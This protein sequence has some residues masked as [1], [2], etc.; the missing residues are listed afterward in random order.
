[1]IKYIVNWYKE[2]QLKHHNCVKNC[3]LIDTYTNSWKQSVGGKTI[4]FWQTTVYEC[5]ICHR[6]WEQ[7]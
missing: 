6:I 4:T 3:K 2:Y 5:K 1:M 7:D